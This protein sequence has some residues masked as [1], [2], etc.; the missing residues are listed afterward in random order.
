MRKNVASQHV[1]GQVNARAD[2]A[3]LTASVSVTVS[4]DGGAQAAGAGVLTHLG[5]GAWDY[6]PTQAETN[7]NHIAFQFTHASGVSQLINV[8]PVSF[9]PHD[10][11]DL[12][13]TGI[14]T[15][16]AALVVIDDFI[17]TEVAAIKA[18]TDNLPADPADASDLLALLTV[19]QADA[20]NIQSRLPAALVGGRMASN[21]EVVGDK[22]GYALTVAEHAAVADKLLGRNIAGGSDA[23]RKVYEALA[24]LRN[25]WVIAAGVLTVYAEDDVT[26]LFT[27]AITRT[28]GDPITQMDP[29]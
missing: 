17:D 14:D 25:R 8:Y 2:G 10:T 15:I 6:A 3:P 23:G 24:A 7:A 21:A 13:L 19:L 1:A 9:D 18:K 28:A 26:P 22:T 5:G 29:A 20:D 27:A 12:G 16:L 4:K 11:A